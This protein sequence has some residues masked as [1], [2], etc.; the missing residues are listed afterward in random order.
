MRLLSM[1][2]DLQIQRLGA[3]VTREMFSP[4]GKWVFL[5]RAMAP[6]RQGSVQAQAEALRRMVQGLC[7]ARCSR[8]GP[9][10]FSFVDGPD[11]VCARTEPS[12]PSIVS[13]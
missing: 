6:E 7:N 11:R 1:I 3:R 12:T 2:R 5:M 4:G 8:Y 13:R 9:G 10:R